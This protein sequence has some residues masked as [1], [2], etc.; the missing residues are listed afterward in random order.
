MD[1]F[2]LVVASKSA[3]KPAAISW[4]FAIDRRIDQLVSHANEACANTRRDELIAAIVAAAETEPE[5][6][7]HAVIAWRK[8]QV[9][10]VVLEVEQAAQ[11][12]TIPRYRPG[13]RR[14]G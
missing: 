7:L 2:D 5:G 9:L 14:I 3:T 11:I 13:R 6:L 4:P 12:V 1:G 10:D 8:L